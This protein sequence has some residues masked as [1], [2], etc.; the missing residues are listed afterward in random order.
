VTC[1]C[2]GFGMGIMGMENSGFMGVGG[3]TARGLRH[4]RRTCGTL[5]SS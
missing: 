5:S 3:R 4:G 1:V 2:M